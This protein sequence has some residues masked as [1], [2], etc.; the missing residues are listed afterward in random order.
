MG[1]L[2]LPRA[3]MSAD[4][5]AVRPRVLRDL[6][7]AGD[8]LLDKGEQAADVPALPLRLPV[9]SP[10]PRYQAWATGAFAHAGASARM[11]RARTRLV[12]TRGGDDRRSA[13]C[14]RPA[15][16]AAAAAAAAPLRRYKPSIRTWHPGG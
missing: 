7:S 5:G 16:A 9:G 12:T 1:V 4:A 8:Q 11:G 10:V 2:G 3:A 14:Y 6:H 13:E 15:A